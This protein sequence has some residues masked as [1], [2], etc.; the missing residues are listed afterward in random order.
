MRRYLASFDPTFLGGTGTSAQL[1]AVRRDYGVVAEKKALAGT[2][3]V[4]HSSFTYLIDREGRLRALMPYGRTADDY[5][6]DV[7]LLLSERK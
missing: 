7:K 2:Y 6:H 5:A 1:A 3:T 4:A